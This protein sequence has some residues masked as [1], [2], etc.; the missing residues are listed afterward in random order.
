MWLEYYRARDYET[1][2]ESKSLTPLRV[3]H[4]LEED[5]QM[6]TREVKWNADFDM[7]RKLVNVRDVDGLITADTV[8]WRNIDEFEQARDLLD[9]WKESQ[10]A[11]AEDEAGLRRHGC[12]GCDATAA[13]NGR[14]P[15]PTTSW[16]R[17]R[18]P[19][20]KSWRGATAP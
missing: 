1:T 16:H 18:R 13:E 11:S 19:C 10:Q 6:V 2:L 14:E 5:I 3:Q 17:C 8:P 20:S 15:D 7:K 9:D 12:M 4:L